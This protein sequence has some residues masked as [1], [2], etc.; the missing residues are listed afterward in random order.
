NRMIN[1][2]CRRLAQEEDQLASQS[3]DSSARPSAASSTAALSASRV[4]TPADSAKIS[5]EALLKAQE[6][7]RAQEVAIARIKMEINRKQTKMLLRKKL[8]ESKLK[9]AHAVASSATAPTTPHGEMDS[10]DMSTVDSPALHG[11][12]SSQSLSSAS[13]SN[14]SN[15]QPCRVSE[16]A[17]QLVVSAPCS[18]ARKESDQAL[19]GPSSDVGGDTVTSLPECG[20]CEQMIQRVSPE[21]RS[22][23][24]SNI[25]ALLKGAT[26]SKNSELRSIMR[27]TSMLAQKDFEKLKLSASQLDERLLA[28]Q[29]RLKEQRDDVSK[30]ISTLHAEL[31][32]VDME[33]GILS[34]SQAANRGYS[35]ALRPK[36]SSSHGNATSTATTSGSRAAVLRNEIA[37]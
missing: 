30:R 29:A 12:A 3:L 17:G 2:E 5:N 16:D 4:S 8:H 6:N 14:A 37:A 20:P 36:A 27:G 34:Y 9:R 33:L 28:R 24:L 35:A 1:K 19:A 15:T 13:D 25:M 22:V 21:I 23:F 10:P 32:L 26:Q 18:P 7:I 31:D 11:S